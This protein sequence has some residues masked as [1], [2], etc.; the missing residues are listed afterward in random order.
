MLFSLLQVLDGEPGHF[1]PTQTASEEDSYHGVITHAAQIG[2]IEYVEESFSLLSSQPVS[3]AHAMLLHSF[4][5]SDSCGKIGAQQATVRRLVCQPANCREAQVD[6][7]GRVMGLFE[8]Y[9]INE[10]L[11][12]C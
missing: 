2:G 12:S 7:G 6:C 11:R 1:R 3:N 9:S 4:Y 10:S 5:P 8:A